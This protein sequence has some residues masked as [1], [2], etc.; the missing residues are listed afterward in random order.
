MA[1]SPLRVIN[2]KHLAKLL[3]DMAILMADWSRAHAKQCCVKEAEAAY[4]EAKYRIVQ[5]DFSALCP[6]EQ[7][8]VVQVRNH[9]G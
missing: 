6:P 9:E 5:A 8:S 3:A 7:P 2:R 4:I 1:E